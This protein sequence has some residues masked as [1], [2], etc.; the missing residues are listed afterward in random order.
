MPAGEEAKINDSKRD[1]EEEQREKEQQE[2]QEE[3]EE[4]DKGEE[5]TDASVNMND[6]WHANVN[7]SGD[8]ETFRGPGVRSM[9]LTA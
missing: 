7:R 8:D 9:K 6:S 5:V 1:R 3:Q 2:K 4:R